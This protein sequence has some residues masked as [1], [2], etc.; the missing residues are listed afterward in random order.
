MDEVIEK[1]KLFACQRCDVT[2]LYAFAGPCVESAMQ[3]AAVTAAT[4]NEFC[5][6]ATLHAR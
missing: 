2:G 4:V 6:N 5:T 3:G 1:K